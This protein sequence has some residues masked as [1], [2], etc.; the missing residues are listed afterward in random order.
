MFLAAIHTAGEF[1]S[2]GANHNQVTEKGEVL[3]HIK[4]FLQGYCKGPEGLTT[5]R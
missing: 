2:G 4:R 1:I 3:V 5:T